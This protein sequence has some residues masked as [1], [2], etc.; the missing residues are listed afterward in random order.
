MSEVV[1]T[2]VASRGEGGL[3]PDAPVEPPMVQRAS[4]SPRKTN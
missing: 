2:E 4:A 1:E 3:V